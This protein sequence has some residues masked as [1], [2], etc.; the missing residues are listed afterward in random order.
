MD[1]MT[2]K[3]FLDKIIIRPTKVSIIRAPTI[4]FY[5]FELYHIMDTEKEELIDYSSLDG[6][7]SESNKEFMEAFWE[8]FIHFI[9]K[10]MGIDFDLD[11]DNKIKNHIHPGGGFHYFSFYK[12]HH[13]IF[14]DAILNFRIP[15]E[16]MIVDTHMGSYHSHLTNIDE[17]TY[18][19]GY[20]QIF[21]YDLSQR[22]DYLRSVKNRELSSVE[23]LLIFLLIT[24][25]I[26]MSVKKIILRHW[27]WISDTQFDKIYSH[28][29]NILNEDFSKEF[30][31]SLQRQQI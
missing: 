27:M 4:D 28:Y 17:D 16:S 21:D 10:E 12:L 5:F 25:E 7:H 29:R 19:S 23:M 20:W 22:Y 30:V 14:L 6:I 24:P 31:I 3:D 1:K 13:M 18:S 8:K 11:I 2:K 26:K 15:T 9:R